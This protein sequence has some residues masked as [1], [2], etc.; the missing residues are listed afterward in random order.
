[1][2][3]R[4]GYGHLPHGQRNRTAADVRH[5]LTNCG[6]NLGQTGSVAYLF[7]RKGLLL[8]EK[9]SMKKR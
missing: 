1:M 9:L 6:G 8:L 2:V 5:A 4:R 7:N 3:R